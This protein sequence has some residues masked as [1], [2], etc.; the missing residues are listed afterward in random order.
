MLHSRPPS[1]SPRTSSKP[2][3]QSD[4]PAASTVRRRWCRTW[5]RRPARALRSRRPASTAASASASAAGTW[6]RIASLLRRCVR[7]PRRT[8]AGVGRS[9]R[10]RALAR[11]DVR[12]LHAHMITSSAR[13]APAA[14][15]ACMIAMMS[16]G[17]APSALS[18]R[19]T[20]SSV[21]PSSSAT[22]CAAPSETSTFS[23]GTTAV[24]PSRKRVWLRHVVVRRDP[25]RQVARAPPRP[26]D[27]HVGADH[28]RAGALVDDDA[29][30]RVH[31]RSAAARCAP[32]GREASR[33][34]HRRHSNRH[35][36]RIDGLGRRVAELAADDVRAGGGPC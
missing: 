1:T 36:R 13:S 18:A 25:H 26:A 12:E 33:L 10:R 34:I 32:S 17:V 7:G 19:T 14:F 22:S 8:S 21:T 30:R 2:T 15:S 4:P 23:C 16:R 35:R 9:L 28:D 6:P 5:S 3:R 24:C 31:R 27:A 29:R 20:A 11:N